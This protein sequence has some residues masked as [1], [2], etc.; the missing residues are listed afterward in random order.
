MTDSRQSILDALN[1]AFAKKYNSLAQY[2]LDAEPYVE[3]G[4]EAALAQIRGIAASDRAMADRLAEVIERLEGIPQVGTYDPLVADLNY[5]ALDYLTGVL[6]GDLERQVIEY[7][8]GLSASRS[9]P[10]AQALFETLCGATREQIE[11][12]HSLH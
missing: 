9:E 3:P 8:T 1:Q 7:E 4:G 10:G 5:L 11:K 2:I 6:A 12:L